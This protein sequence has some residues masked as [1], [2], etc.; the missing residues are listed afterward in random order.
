MCSDKLLKYLAE[1]QPIQIDLDREH[2]IP[3]ER[4]G[5]L[6]ILREGRKRPHDRSVLQRWSR[7]GRGPLRVRLE[8]VMT[9]KGLCTTREAVHRFLIRWAESLRPRRPMPPEG[10]TD[11]PDGRAHLP[12]PTSS[13]SRRSASAAVT[14]LDQIGLLARTGGHA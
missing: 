5:H 3:I 4:A 7:D 10:F 6:R 13:P 1:G 12:W 8:T 14:Y 2:P 11:A 9:G